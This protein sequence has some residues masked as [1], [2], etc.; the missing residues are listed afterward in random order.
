MSKM[1]KRVERVWTMMFRLMIILMWVSFPALAQELPTEIGP[2]ESVMIKVPLGE[3]VYCGPT[4]EDCLRDIGNW[5]SAARIQDFQERMVKPKRRYSAEI[6]VC[7]RT[8][9]ILWAANE[10]CEGEVEDKLQGE[11]ARLANWLKMEEYER[12]AVG[13]MGENYQ[14]DAV[15]E[16]TKK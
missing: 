2:G 3:V 5:F 6:L 13:F 9:R 16:D 14:I 4:H 12:V 8:E 11:A 10:K 1:E 15:L 7:K